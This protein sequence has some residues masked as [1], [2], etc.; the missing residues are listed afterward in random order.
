[1]DREGFVW[2]AQ[3]YGSCIVRYDPDGKVERRVAIPA[4]QPSSLCFGG[5]DLTEIFVTS[6]GQSEPMPI[7][8]PGYDAQTG[9]FG[10]ALFHLNVGIVGQP[11][12]VADIAV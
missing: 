10:G 11:P 6:A 4:K 9:Y 12:L 5:P 8:P 2:S 1:V 3:W 7:M